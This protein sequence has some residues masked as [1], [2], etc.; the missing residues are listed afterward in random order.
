MT[1]LP[2]VIIGGHLVE[3]PSVPSNTP[4]WAVKHAALFLT[5][6]LDMELDLWHVTDDKGCFV[7]EATK[8]SQLSCEL[9]HISLPP[10]TA[11]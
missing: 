6:H 2:K 3:L 10:G 8:V 5:N 1:N 11:A 4:V 7:N 9:L